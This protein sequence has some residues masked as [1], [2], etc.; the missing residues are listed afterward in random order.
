MH[1][2]HDM[3][4]ADFSDYQQAGGFGNMGGFNMGGMGGNGQNYTFTMNGQ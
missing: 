2:E 3:G 1:A 4:G